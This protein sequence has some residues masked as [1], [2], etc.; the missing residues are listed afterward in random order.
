MRKKKKKDKKSNVC[1]LSINSFLISNRYNAILE[2]ARESHPT[3]SEQDLR[4]LANQEFYGVE[5]S[6]EEGLLC[7]I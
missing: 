6:D 3:L 1:L 5:D 7:Y 4:E 2:K